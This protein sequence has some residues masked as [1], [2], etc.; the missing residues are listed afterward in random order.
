M[1]T[2]SQLPVTSQVT[3]ADQLPISQGGAVCSVSVG[4]LLAGTQPAILVETGSLLGRTSLGPGGPDPVGVGVGLLLNSNTL[5]ATGADHAT[6]AAQGTLA[7]SDKVVLSSGGVP[8]LLQL[9]L[10]RDL[11]Y[12]GSNISIDHNGTISAT[13]EDS[14]PSVASGYSITNLPTVTT[15]SSDDLVAISHAGSDRTI[16]YVDFIDGQTIDQAQVASPASGTDS[17]LVAQGGNLM[18]RQTLAAMWV[19]LCSQLPDYRMPTLELTGGTTLSAAIHNCRVLICS[20]P[21]SVI[22]VAANLGSGFSCNLINMSDGNVTF[23]GSVTSS[24]GTSV[25]APGQAAT[26][27]CATYS[28]GT[29][30]YAWITATT[31]SID[32]PA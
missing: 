17:F 30:I 10:L 27:T 14:A 3:A 19:W 4:A 15:I 18:L 20:Q 7:L 16:A 21:I 9:S 6:F 1:P 13:L 11:F 32:P 5:V 23:S 2:I 31:L 22:V 25:L 8:K 24:S 28:G 26:L 29:L 12:A